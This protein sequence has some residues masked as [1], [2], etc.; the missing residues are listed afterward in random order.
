MCRRQDGNSQAKG[1]VS[2]VAPGVLAQAQL[3][4]PSRNLPHIP[5][6][7]LGKFC[8]KAGTLELDLEVRLWE[9]IA[10]ILDS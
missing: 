1:P 4:F 10:V 5:A 6:E 3:R 7:P 9:D 2:T 8:S